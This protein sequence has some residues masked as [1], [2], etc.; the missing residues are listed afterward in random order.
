MVATN[1]YISTGRITGQPL[2]GKGA[3]MIFEA[4]A[5]NHRKSIPT[6]MRCKVNHFGVAKSACC[7]QDLGSKR[8]TRLLLAQVDPGKE[9]P[10]GTSL[11]AHWI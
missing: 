9:H 11:G 4:V 7:P 2:T 10:K 6:E 1:D 8:D 5:T 3:E